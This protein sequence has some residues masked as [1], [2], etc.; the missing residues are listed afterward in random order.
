MTGQILAPG[1]APLKIDVWRYV[2]HPPPDMVHAYDVKRPGDDA[3]GYFLAGT[4]A[5]LIG[6]VVRWSWI[7]DDPWQVRIDV[8]QDGVSVPGFPAG[9]SGRLGH[10]AQGPVPRR[11]RIAEL[12]EPRQRWQAAA[13]PR[14][15]RDDLQ[16]TD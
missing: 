12:V 11:L 14:G 10:G 16:L 8:R 4:G 2:R 9:Y 6:K 1:Q 15:L 13:D 5:S 3:R 7:W